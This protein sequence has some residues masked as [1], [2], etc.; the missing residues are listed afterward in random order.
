MSTDHAWWG[1]FRGV[2]AGAALCLLPVPASADSPPSKPGQ[3]SVVQRAYATFELKGTNGYK[4]TVVGSSRGVT[5]VAAGRGERVTYLDRE[6]RGGLSGIQARFG[7]LG[8][9]SVHF[10]PNGKSPDERREPGRQC[11]SLDNVLNQSGAFTGEID[12]RGERNF[13]AV[14]RR[15][16]SGSAT[17]RRRLRCAHGHGEASKSPVPRLRASQMRFPAEGLLRILSF[18]IFDESFGKEKIAFVAQL[19]EDRGRLLI[20]RTV[21]AIGKSKALEVTDGSTVALVGPPHPFLGEAEHN[22]CPPRGPQ[23]WRGSL[24]VPFP[25]MGM[26]R[27]TGKSFGSEL[28]RQGKCP[29]PPTSSP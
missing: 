27:L 18:E 12:F 16:V 4:I 22:G 10:Q 14:H 8:E 21:A 6:G 3:R 20:L 1:A 11:R 17:P 5:L 23:L 24:R 25:G 26:V 7:K 2:L 15:H 13:T 19:I 9:I 28:K 29:K